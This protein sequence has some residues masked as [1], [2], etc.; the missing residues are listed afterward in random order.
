EASA[1]QDGSGGRVH[2]HGVV[3]GAGR[4]LRAYDVLVISSWTEGTPIVLL[5]AMAAGV[6]VVTTAVGGIPDVVSDAEAVLVPPGD[7]QAM[8]AAFGSILGGSSDAARVRADAARA[9]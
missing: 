3:T 5:E 6:P 1:R 4:Y 8:A 7:V 2:W 9:R